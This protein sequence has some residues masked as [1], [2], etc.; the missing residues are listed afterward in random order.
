MLVTGYDQS[1]DF[2]FHPRSFPMDARFVAHVRPSTASATLLAT[3]STD[4][5]TLRLLDPSILRMTFRASATRSWTVDSVV[6]D[7][8]R[9]D[10][11]SPELVGFRAQID[12]RRTVTRGA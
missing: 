4:D 8:V 6:V 3:L 10:V 5:E 2:D 9:L 1:V 11:P 12:F 7:V